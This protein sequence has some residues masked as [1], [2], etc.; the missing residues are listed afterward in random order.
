MTEPTHGTNQPDQPYAYPS[1]G[2]PASTSAGTAPGGV[3]LADDPQPKA[4]GAR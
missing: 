2:S 1:A 4:A 3:A